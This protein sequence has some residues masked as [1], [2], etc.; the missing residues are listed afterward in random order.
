VVFRTRGDEL[1]SD[2]TAS[3]IRT[4]ALSR[5]KEVIV[6]AEV[7]IARTETPRYE[8]VPFL[9]PDL[10]RTN[11][12]GLNPFTLMRRFTD[13]MDR[14]FGKT[15]E[16]AAWRPVIEVKRDKDRMLVHAELPGLKKEDVKVT[17]TGDLL[18][19]EGERKFAKEENR[20]G[21]IHSERSYGKFYRA[22]PLPE[23]V[24]AEIA[25][26]EFAD[27]VLEIAIPVPEVKPAIKEIPVGDAKPK[28]EVKH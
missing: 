5:V 1:E 28:V 15:S 24:N 6:M 27:G 10:F 23:G 19:I 9:G 8:V 12:L 26:A 13:E 18:E 17:I 3:W 2:G 16:T 14:A 20:N 11:L 4:C 25:A 22:I 21:Y 7:K